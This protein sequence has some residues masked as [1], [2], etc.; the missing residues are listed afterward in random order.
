V[1]ERA[2]TFAVLFVDINSLDDHD[3]IVIGGVQE[4]Q[5]DVYEDSAAQ[6][7]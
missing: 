4:E 7:E 2:S 5:K 1:N 3:R 6:E